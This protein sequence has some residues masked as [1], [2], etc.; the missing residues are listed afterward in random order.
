MCT[1]AGGK[2]GRMAPRTAV[3][4]LEAKEVSWGITNHQS[5]S[6]ELFS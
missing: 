5:S 6:D 2:R 1:V 3:S 4:G